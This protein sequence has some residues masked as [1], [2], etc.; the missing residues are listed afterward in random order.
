MKLFF[1]CPQLASVPCDQCV[2]PE[3][4]VS[5]DIRRSCWTVCNTFFCISH[6]KLRTVPSILKV[7]PRSADRNS[8]AGL[9]SA[10]LPAVC[11]QTKLVSLQ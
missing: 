10:L 4:R 9:S 2:F 5:A 7:Q 6:Q 1:F 8:S 3:R 11:S